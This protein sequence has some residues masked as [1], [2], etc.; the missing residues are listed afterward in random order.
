MTDYIQYVADKN[1]NELVVD[2]DIMVLANP[3][4]AEL[5]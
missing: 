3:E 4:I 2:N 1:K 5:T